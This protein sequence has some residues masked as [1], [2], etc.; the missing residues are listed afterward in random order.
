MPLDAL[1]RYLKVSSDDE[2]IDTFPTFDP[3]RL[4]NRSVDCVQC[5]MALMVCQSM[6]LISE[7]LVTYAAFYRN[8]YRRRHAVVEG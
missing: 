2:K 4:V 6:L 8:P 1:T 5:S 3:T 7:I